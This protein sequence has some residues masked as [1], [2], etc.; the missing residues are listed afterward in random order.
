MPGAKY[1]NT[2]FLLESTH[3]L[4]PLAQKLEEEGLFLLYCRQKPDGCW[5]ASFEAEMDAPTP[6]ES[7]QRLMP[8]IEAHEKELRECN[9]RVFDVGFQATSGQPAYECEIAP[10][11]LA[12][13][14]NLNAE[15]RVTIYPPSNE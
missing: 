13:I 4:T 8:V 7:L 3:D 9:R 14:A 5:L 1:L 15:I 6:G 2:D 12:R 11:I 10:T